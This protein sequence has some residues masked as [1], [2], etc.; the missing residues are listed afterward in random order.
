MTTETLLHELRNDL[1]SI[2]ASINTNPNALG[3]LNGKWA[4]LFKAIITAGGLAMP[5]LVGLNVWTVTEINGLKIEHAK[6][7]AR[8][9]S[10]VSVGPRYS[11]DMAIADQYR[12]K[13]DVLKTVDEKIREA[14]RQP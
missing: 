7:L 4:I 13:E 14:I 10:F 1:D 9:E 11:A 3:N 2:R 5:F 12:L 8:F 6:L